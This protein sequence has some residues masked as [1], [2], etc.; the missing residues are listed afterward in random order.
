MRRHT[1]QSITV[2]KFGGRPVREVKGT[3][4]IQEENDEACTELVGIG[5]KKRGSI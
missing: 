2:G 4:E 3:A 5:M 1:I